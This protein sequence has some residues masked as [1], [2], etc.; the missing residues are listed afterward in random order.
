MVWL[1]P[2]GSVFVDNVFAKEAQDVMV[3]FGGK[4]VPTRHLRVSKRV[5]ERLAG[6]LVV[7]SMFL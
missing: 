4:R 2:K 5:T 7:F 3:D 6:F 1:G